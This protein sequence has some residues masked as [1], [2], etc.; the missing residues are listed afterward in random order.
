VW[1]ELKFINRNETM[2]FIVWYI[3]ATLGTSSTDIIVEVEIHFFSDIDGGRHYRSCQAK[4][5]IE[6]C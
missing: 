6:S 2:M 3:I 1:D 4:S 5:N